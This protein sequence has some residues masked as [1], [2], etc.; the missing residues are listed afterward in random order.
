[1]IKPSFIWL[2]ISPDPIKEKIS[3]NG[4]V[5]STEATTSTVETTG[6]IVA[7]GPGAY[8]TEGFFLEVQHKVGE[9]IFF[10]GAPAYA[11]EAEDGTR[12]LLLK[13]SDVKAVI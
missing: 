11:Y 10:G 1:M 2:L 3:A 9:R 13:D 8:T 4:I 12:Y 5:T 7:T 6:T